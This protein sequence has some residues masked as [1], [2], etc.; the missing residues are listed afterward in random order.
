MCAAIDA[1]FNP[2]Q[3]GS[4]SLQTTAVNIDMLTILPHGK[5]SSSNGSYFPGICQYN[6][7]MLA[8]AQIYTAQY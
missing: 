3:L 1:P 5:D 6:M 7:I 8:I 4:S 2:S